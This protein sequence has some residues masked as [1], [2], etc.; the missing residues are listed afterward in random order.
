MKSFHLLME[1]LFNQVDIVEI[2]LSENLFKKK[3]T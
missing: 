2:K 3:E 1:E